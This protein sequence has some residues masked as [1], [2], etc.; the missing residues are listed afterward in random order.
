MVNA[1]ETFDLVKQFDTLVAVDGINL[2]I[3]K[4]ELFGLLGPNGAGKTT[5]LKMLITLLKP[6]SGRATVSGIDVV[7]H[8]DEVRKIIGYVAQESALDVRLTA[9][10]NLQFFGELYNIPRQVLSERIMQVL[11]LVELDKRMNDLVAHYSGGMKRRLEIARGLLPTPEVLFLDEPTSG[12][13]PQTRRVMWEFLHRL[14]KEWDLTMV[15]TTH[16]L[17]EADRELDRVA[18]IDKGKIMC[19]GTPAELKSAYGKD[20]VEVTLNLGEGREEIDEALK[21]RLLALDLGGEVTFFKNAV[22]VAVTD[23]RHALPA[24]LHQLDTAGVE[25]DAMAVKTPSLD[26]VFIKYTGRGIREEGE[27]GEETADTKKYEARVY[28]KLRA[29]V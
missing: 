7:A 6:T 2:Q 19:L 11:K 24:I 5:T 13:D 15:V 20:L 10:E 8:P 18:I 28:G 3:Q 29:R 1:V 14:R 21:T 9:R 12:L 25:V 4:G 26:D 27:N 23:G 22:R 16:Y 17:E